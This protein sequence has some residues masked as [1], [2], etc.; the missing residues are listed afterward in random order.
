MAIARG[1]AFSHVGMTDLEGM[2]QF[3]TCLIGLTVTDRRRPR[4]LAFTVIN[5][6]SFRVGGVAALRE[7]DERLRTEPVSD[8]TPVAHG[9]AVSVY[10]GDAEGDRIELSCHTPWY[11]TQP[12]R[13]PVD[14]AKEVVMRNLKARAKCEASGPERSGAPRWH[15]EWASSDARA[16]IGLALEN[17]AAVTQRARV[18][19][20]GAGRRESHL[21]VPDRP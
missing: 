3:Y 5:Q 9:N 20:R 19:G 2:E 18:A 16:R 14:L 8:I 15:G 17:R 21:T 4:D 10:F 6:L 13:K 7:L 1:I 11:V 12:V